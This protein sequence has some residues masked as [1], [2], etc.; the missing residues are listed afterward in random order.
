VFPV[1]RS[2]FKAVKEEMFKFGVGIIKD[3]FS[4][5]PLKEGL[6]NRVRQ[7][8]TNLSDRASA[9]IINM[10]GSGK[11]T[12]KNRKSSILPHFA[13]TKRRRQTGVTSM[14]NKQKRRK[15]RLVIK[16]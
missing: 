5:I 14:G 10:A 15:R 9:S 6:A 7:F 1:L 2:S 11:R 12:Y 16:G 13:S 4:S 3:G 8:G